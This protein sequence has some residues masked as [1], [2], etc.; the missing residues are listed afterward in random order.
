MGSKYTRKDFLNRF[1]ASFAGA[2]MIDSFYRPL[3]TQTTGVAKMLKRRIPKTGEE[4]PAI[5]LG[6]WQTLDVDPDPSSLAP[7]KE[8]LA[9][10]LNAGG[11]VVDSSPMYGRSEEIFGILSK[12]VS[13]ND[14]KKF[15]LATKVW[16]RGESAGKAQIEA[17]FRKMKAD[18]IDLFQIHN[19]L[20]TQTHLKTLRDLKD[21]SRIRY[22][23][24]THFTSS[25]FSEMEKISIKEKPDFL[26]IPYSIITR[27]AEQRI[28]PFALENGIAVLINRPFEEGGLFHKAKGKTL[29]EYFKEW[30]CNSF[31]QAFLKYLLSHPAVTAVIPATSK[32]SHLKDNLQAGL[33]RF[34]DSK[35]R[36]VFLSNLLDALD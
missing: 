32:V 31:A 10:F 11:G 9:E 20:D 13:A 15:F 16:T 21:K 27:E 2:A 17:S 25:A 28:L 12:D 35:E 24:L 23:G 1:A 7:L 26:Q 4:I 6:T 29:P 22:I 8:V 33:G 36:K 3:F 30:D 14:K 5:G 18:Q 34:P 19:L